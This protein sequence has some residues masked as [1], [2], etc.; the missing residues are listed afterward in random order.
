MTTDTIGA[1][2]SSLLAAPHQTFYCSVFPTCKNVTCRS[3]LQQHVGSEGRI[4]RAW[5]EVEQNRCAEGAR[6]SLERKCSPD[7]KFGCARTASLVSCSLRKT[8]TRWTEAESAV[9]G[10]SASAEVDFASRA[11]H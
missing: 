9:S 6:D 8:E 11:A 1:S 4:E 2:L 5:M 10:M 7:D 3:V